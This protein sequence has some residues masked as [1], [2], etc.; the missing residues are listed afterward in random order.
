M[1]PAEIVSDALQRK[2]YAAGGLAIEAPTARDI[3]AQRKRGGGR[4]DELWRGSRRPLSTRGQLHRQNPERHEACRR[5]SG[6]SVKILTGRQPQDREGTGP[7]HSADCA[8][9]RR[10]SDRIIMQF[11]APHESGICTKRTCR[12]GKALYFGAADV[13][14]GSFAD[15]APRHDHVCFTPKADILVAPIYRGSYLWLQRRESRPSD[16]IR[17]GDVAAF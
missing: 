10:R 2:G 3:C 5:T 8:G 7:F 6:T 1:A 11:T 15:I 12:P 13:R 9:P 17:Y 16:H 4:P 14:S